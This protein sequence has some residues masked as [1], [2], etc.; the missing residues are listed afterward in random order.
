MNSIWRGYLYG[1]V[2]ALQWSCISDFSFSEGSWSGP[3]TMNALTMLP[4]SSSGAGT[5]ALSTTAGCSMRMLS[6]SNGPMR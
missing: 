5:T 6:I 3:S 4:R 2:R 1:A